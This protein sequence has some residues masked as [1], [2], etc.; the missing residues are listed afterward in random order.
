MYYSS[1]S[2]TPIN[3]PSYL[4][5]HTTKTQN[6]VHRKK[7]Y[8]IHI[9]GIYIYSRSN[10][11]KP[12]WIPTTERAAVIMGHNLVRTT[13]LLFQRKRNLFPP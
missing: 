12:R 9:Q 4:Q 7:T 3:T 5:R 6:R 13:Q 11:A 8:H 2:A 10:S 1:P